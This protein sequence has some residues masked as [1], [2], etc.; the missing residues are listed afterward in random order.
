MAKT[1]RLANSFYPHTISYLLPLS[2][3]CHLDFLPHCTLQLNLQPCADV[4]NLI[5]SICVKPALH[6]LFPYLHG[7]FTSITP[8]VKP[9]PDIYRIFRSIT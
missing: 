9:K 3:S 2:P 6:C 1:V 5:H 8:C 4:I 7:H